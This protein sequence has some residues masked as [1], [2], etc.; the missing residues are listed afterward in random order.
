MG[1]IILVGRHKNRVCL[2]KSN[3]STYRESKRYEF[4]FC[5]CKRSI[6]CI[7]DK[8]CDELPNFLF[9]NRDTSH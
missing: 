4:T 1:N 7:C 3:I 9:P 2:I 8:N 6:T 5:N